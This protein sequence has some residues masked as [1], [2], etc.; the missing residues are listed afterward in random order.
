MPQAVSAMQTAT[1]AA[2]LRVLSLSSEPQH[3]V[4]YSMMKGLCILFALPGYV[5]RMDQL[6]LP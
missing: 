5:L 2:K 6:H 1:D 3:Y 4:S